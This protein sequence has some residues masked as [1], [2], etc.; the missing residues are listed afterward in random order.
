M[1]LFELLHD[2]QFGSIDTSQCACSVNRAD[3]IL[4]T[5]H[6]LVGNDTADSCL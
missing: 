1:I 5:L 2:Y 6:F 4:Y 3:N